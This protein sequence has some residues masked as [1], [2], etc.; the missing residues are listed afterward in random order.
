MQARLERVDA[1]LSALCASNRCPVA[2]RLLAVRVLSEEAS[3][4]D[5]V[6]E[7]IRAHDGPA[8]LNRQVRDFVKRRS[9]GEL[10]AHAHQRT[11]QIIFEQ[12]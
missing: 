7:H 1:A 9:P 6:C 5:V 4:S 12:F 3:T 10:F 2:E 11:E 8:L